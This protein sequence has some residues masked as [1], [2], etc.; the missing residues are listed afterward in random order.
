MDIGADCSMRLGRARY[1]AQQ[2]VQVA[3]GGQA[4]LRAFGEAHADA[5]LA[6]GHPVGDDD[7]SASGRD[8]HERSVARSRAMGP[9]HRKRLAAEGMPRVVDR[10]RS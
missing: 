2:P 5:A 6:L 8:A 3:E 4:D 1:T 9:R 7:E 10:D